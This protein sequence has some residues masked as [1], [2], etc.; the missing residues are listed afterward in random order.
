[1]ANASSAIWRGGDTQKL[2]GVVGNPRHLG[3]EM[4][5]A[6][7]VYVPLLRFPNPNLSIV[8]HSKNNPLALAMALREA[9]WS[10]DRDLPVY[11]LQTMSS[12][13]SESGSARRTQT[14]LLAG[15][16]LLALCLAAVG[17]YGVV[18]EAVGQR[19]REI[20]VRMA[21]GARTGNVIGMVLR[22]S[23]ALAA[24]G[25]LLGI[26]ASFFLTRFLESLLFGV[27][28]RDAASFAGAAILLLM[29]AL[30][31]G[32]VPARRAARIDPA[33]VSRGQ[34]GLGIKA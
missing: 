34:E 12:L 22:R 7:E 6:A 4:D 25:I 3:R 33:N 31:A 15:F 1:M 24:A 8:V 5:V 14:L 32:Y 23:M 21:L 29:V 11:E 26:C 28:A 27:K 17:I 9:V 18:S 20:G 19:T 30:L 16:G 13:V 10:I 2:V